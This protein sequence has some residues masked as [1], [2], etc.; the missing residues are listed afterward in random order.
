MKPYFNYAK[1]MGISFLLLFVFGFFGMGYV[2]SKLYDYN[3]ALKTVAEVSANYQLL[4]YG[5]LATVLMNASSLFLAIFTYRWL[6]KFSSTLAV[7]AALLLMTGAIVSLVNELNSFSIL[8]IS[9]NSVN[10]EITALHLSLYQAG[11]YI[12]TL[13]WGLWLL[14]VGC[15]LLFQ[16]R[17]VKL[18]GLL[19]IISGLGYLIDSVF[20]LLWNQKILV[21][22]YTFLGE[23]LFTLWALFQLKSEFTSIKSTLP[24]KHFPANFLR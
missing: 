20:Y 3:S 24:E 19:L 6:R 17:W 9:Q 8:H 4:R 13:F 7:S 2:P 15:A 21:S 11:V 1:L 22:D 14:P 18:I 16:S 12:A 5:I 10:L 23:V